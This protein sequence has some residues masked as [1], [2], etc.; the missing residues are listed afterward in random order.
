MASDSSS[1][2][3]PLPLP[4]IISDKPIQTSTLDEQK[5]QTDLLRNQQGMW[6]KYLQ[7]FGLNKEELNEHNNQIVNELKVQNEQSKD[8]IEQDTRDKKKDEKGEKLKDK[9]AKF[10]EKIKFWKYFPD[11]FKNIK[12]IAKNS[13]EKVK[14]WIEGLAE[15]FWYSLVDPSG[16]LITTVVALII[17]AL[18]NL[19]TLAMNLLGT[20]IPQI[21][22]M[23]IAFLPQMFR[24]IETLVLKLV[25]MAP[26]FINALVKAIPILI[27]GLVRVLPVLVKALIKVTI[28][29]FKAVVLL[30]PVLL[31]GVWD[32]AKGIWKELV[33]AWPELKKALIDGMASLGKSILKI[34]DDI[35]GGDSSETMKKVKDFFNDLYIIMDYLWMELKGFFKD[36]YDALGGEEGIMK[37]FEGV[38][39]AVS[40]IWDSISSFIDE[41]MPYIEMLIPPLM[42]LKD[43]FVRVSL[44]VIKGLK[45]AF[46]KLMIV[47]GPVIDIILWLV[48]TFFKFLIPIVAWLI[49]IFADLYDSYI[50]ILEVVGKV[51][52]W[53]WD[54]GVKVVKW[55]KDLWETVSKAFD[56]VKDVFVETWD[57]LAN[58]VKDGLK[59]LLG[60]FS[61]WFSSVKDEVPEPIN[62]TETSTTTNTGELSGDQSLYNRTLKKTKEQLDKGRQGIEKF[63]ETINKAFNLR[64]IS[65]PNI[66]SMF[67]GIVS[68]AF[69]TAASASGIKGIID[70]VKDSAT[71]KA[72]ERL[73]GEFKKSFDSIINDLKTSFKNFIDWFE[74][75]PLVKPALDAV[76]KVKNALIGGTNPTPGQTTNIKVERQKGSIFNAFQSYSTEDLEKTKAAAAKK[77]LNVKDEKSLRNAFEAKFGANVENKDLLSEYFIRKLRGEDIKAEKFFEGSDEAI[78][79]EM[80]RNIDKLVSEMNSQNKDAKN[81]DKELLDWLNAN[82]GS[83]KTVNTILF[84]SP[85]QVPGFTEAFSN[86]GVK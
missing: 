37:S 16:S 50:D 71:F 49:D 6:T 26:M 10:W 64:T 74:N 52:D 40:D 51:I 43:V 8:K 12:E 56:K 22:N 86:S 18:G 47:I 76:K 45:W 19:V 33:N 66:G 15:W 54:W 34:F 23:V 39:K 58:A 5:S 59:K 65:I 46:D 24:M 63:R 83:G 72:I 29:L 41:M 14:G 11:L 20:V 73:V 38:K 36:I 7:L 9:L 84:T 3:F 30:I 82:S 13:Y 25:K 28:A 53:L 61:N 69:S 75:L 78:T 80:G 81:R 31:K 55:F 62:Q 79:E 42:K 48:K 1:M 77:N 70:D 67:S 44:V 85:K 17:P 2:V 68:N 57:A 60:Y 4:V 32:A 21:I 27:K 35:F